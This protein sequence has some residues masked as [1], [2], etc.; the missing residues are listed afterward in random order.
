M[1][2]PTPSSAVDAALARLDGLDDRPV[3]EHVEV[4]DAVHRSLQD[5]LAT[6][7]EA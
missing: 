5:A 4:F 2:Q 1:S 6:L 7:D 3:G